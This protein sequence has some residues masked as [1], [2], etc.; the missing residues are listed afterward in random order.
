VIAHRGILQDGFYFI[1]KPISKK[2]LAQKIRAVL[3]DT[4]D[5]G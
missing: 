1:P 4:D 2:D 5:G 3:N